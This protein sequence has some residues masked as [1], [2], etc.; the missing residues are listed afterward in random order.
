MSNYEF[1]I[2]LKSYANKYVKDILLI[3]LNDRGKWGTV[4]I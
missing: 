1:N 4:Q 2:V 3:Y